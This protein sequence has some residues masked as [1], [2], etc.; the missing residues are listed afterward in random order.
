ML[1]ITI[2]I[3]APIEMIEWN[4]RV[5]IGNHIHYKLPILFFFFGQKEREKK[6]KFF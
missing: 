6:N 5:I 2:I 3:H 1:I 4:G